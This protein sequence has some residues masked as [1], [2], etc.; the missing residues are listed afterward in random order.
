VAAQ[1]VASGAVL[2]STELVSYV[3]LQ[4]GSGTRKVY[5]RFDAQASVATATDY[6]NAE[7]PVE[8]RK[9]NWVFWRVFAINLTILTVIAEY[10]Q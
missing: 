3:Y 4:E 7:E 9:L 10:K 6:I 5:T 2:S 8:E 1:V